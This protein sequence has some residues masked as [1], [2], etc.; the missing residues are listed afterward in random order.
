M[1]SSKLL[2]PT[3]NI[4]NQFLRYVFVGAAAFLVDFATLIL[5]TEVFH[6]HY[7]LSGIISFVLGLVINYLLSVSWVFNQRALKNMWL[8]I[9]IFSFVGAVGLALNTFFLW[10]L[11]E[12]I[13][14][15][16]ALSK[17]IATMVVFL[18]NFF[19]RKFVLFNK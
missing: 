2:E 8:E 17:V 9:F 7:L 10:F 18:W 11:T 14:L 4:A 19:V 13:S 12:N 6:L 16:Y 1:L 5:L 3:G 15:H